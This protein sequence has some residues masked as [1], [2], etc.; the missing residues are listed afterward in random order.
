MRVLGIETSC[1]ET[2]AAV[3]LDGRDILSN[4]VVSQ[5]RLHS[6][7]GGVVPELACRAHVESLLPVL[8]RALSDAGLGLDGI[9]AVAVTYTPGLVGALLLGVAAAKAICL[10][11][12]KPLVGVDHL[13]AHI[14]AA[15]LTPTPP[16]P[17]HV[18]LVVSGGHTNL[19]LT[20]DVADHEL[21]GST[22]DD[23]V[24][25]AFDKVA[26][27]LG[28]G[29]PGGP[30]VEA[31][32]RDGNPKALRFPRTQLGPG[33]LDFSFS[34]LKTAVLYHC[35]GQNAS[36]K[37]PPRPIPDLPD[38]AA[39]FQAAVVDV[40]VARTF[41]AVEAR[42][43]RALV[44]GGGVACNGP[45]RERLAAEG[46]ARGIAVHLPPKKLCTDNAAMVA[47]LGYQ[48]ALRGRT[49]DLALEVVPTS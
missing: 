34:G 44:C 32:A 22:L 38:V 18:S 42:G 21:L 6:I 9:D 49:A 37:T 12:G 7:Y 14:Y 31:A 5:E 40:L 26:S 29:Y 17:P 4:V 16:V 39:S 19:Y 8:D 35:R 24:G 27:L 36:L 11:R 33:S 46:A 3:V 25:E 41:E 1:D 2:A 10:A 13:Q 47:G 15:Y 30:R 48:L 28:L 20:R 43:A 45:L 23:A